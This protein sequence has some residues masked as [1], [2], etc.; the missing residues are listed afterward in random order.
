MLLKHGGR[1][2]MSAI[3]PLCL[4]DNGPLGFLG[5]RGYSLPAELLPPS[6]GLWSTELRK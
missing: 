6:E 3:A 1:V 5:G 4:R 2:Y